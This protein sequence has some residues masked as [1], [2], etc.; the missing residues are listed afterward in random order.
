MQQT[1]LNKV[2]AEEK[3]GQEKW[4]DVDRSPEALLN[5]ATEELG[6]VAHAINH[7]EGEEAITQEIAEVIGVLSRLYDMVTKE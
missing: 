3:R 6:E 2:L 5:A 1:L 4:G 7:D